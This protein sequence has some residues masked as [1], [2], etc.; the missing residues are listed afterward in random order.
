M[1]I[2]GAVKSD[3]WAMFKRGEGG[4]IVVYPARKNG[5]EFAGM[6]RVEMQAIWEASQMTVPGPPR[7]T[8][9]KRSI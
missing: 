7:R 3:A 9:V 5:V 8:I 2:K 1:T 4:A 6:I